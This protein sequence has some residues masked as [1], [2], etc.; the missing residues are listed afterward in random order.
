M[1]VILV[2]RT[3]YRELRNEQDHRLSFIARLLAQRAARPILIDDRLD[4]QNLIDESRRLD[5]D[6]AYI[7]VLDRHGA[8]LA[9][10]GDETALPDLSGAS[11]RAGAA[12]ARYR[13]AAAPVLEG[14]LGQVHVGVA[15]H[16]LRAKLARI[17][18]IVSAM[19][20]AF[21]A[22]GIL[23]A[24][25][26][27]RSVTRPIERLVEFSSAVRLEGPLPPLAIRSGDEIAELG[28]HLQATAG[29]LQRLHEEARR[30]E[31]AM[32]RVE[33]LAAIGTLAAGAAHEINN[34]LAG[35]RTALERILRQARDPA[36][37]ERYGRVLRDAVARIEAAVSGLLSFARATE[38]HLGSVDLSDAVDRALELAG[39]RLEQARVS[40]LRELDP[41][42][43]AV[44]AD[45][46]KLVRVLLNLVLNACDAIGSGGGLA[47]RAAADGG[48][49][50]VDVSDSGPGVPEE[51]RERIFDP[52]FTTKG[53]GKGTGLGLA[54]SLT[55]VREMGGELSLVPSACGACFRITLRAARGETDAQHP[56]G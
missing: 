22:V 32:A 6:L 43:P 18:G 40:L 14:R 54:V 52:F 55:A 26:V 25:A 37:A 16:G 28:N 19:V 10:S 51:I 30:R 31:R 29:E 49:V 56:A 1:N 27:A 13:E 2:G 42:L 45:E 20:I 53:Q 17:V 38:V 46:G 12:A 35:L 7:V 41:D 8:R 44:R 21:L 24:T 5:P 48:N 34:P 39:P 36:E 9:H 33:H 23:A 47:I 15:E 11:A 50:V 3:A 4:L